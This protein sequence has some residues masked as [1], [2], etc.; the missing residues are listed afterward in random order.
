MALPTA[1]DN[2]FTKLLVAE[3]AAPATPA[4][5]KSVAYAKSDGLWYSKDDAGVETLMSSG[6]ASGIAATIVDAKGDLIAATAA[7]TVARVAVGANGTVLEAASGATAGVQWDY[8]PGYEFDYAQITSDV[9]IT[10]N[11]TEGTSVSIVSGASVAY[12]GSTVVVVE[13]FTPRVGMVATASGKAVIFLLYDGA[14]LVGRMATWIP[15]FV[16]GVRADLPISARYRLTPTNASHQYIVKA[17]NTDPT[18]AA[19]VQ[20][21]AGGTGEDLPTFIRVTKV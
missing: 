5:G 9:T 12:D 19:V 16:S 21:G 20:A 10:A 4:S 2:T 1:S 15:T 11:T 18:N 7:D 8:P 17:H 14:T 3:G 6:A 13:F